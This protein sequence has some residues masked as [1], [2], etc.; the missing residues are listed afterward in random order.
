MRTARAFLCVVVLLPTAGCPFR[1]PGDSERTKPTTYR[2]KIVVTLDAQGLP[3]AIPLVLA[4]DLSTTTC[5]SAWA[6]GTASAADFRPDPNQPPWTVGSVATFSGSSS[7]C[8]WVS[9]RQWSIRAEIIEATFSPDY[10]FVKLRAES[11]DSWYHGSPRTGFGGGLH[12]TEIVSYEFRRAADGL[13][14]HIES[15]FAGTTTS[16]SRDLNDIWGN[17]PSPSATHGSDG[18]RTA[19]DELLVPDATE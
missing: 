13:H 15:N 5:D 4:G 16:F 6:G 8:P 7:P 2:G 11:R 18:E 17:G 9:M 10:S 1:G 19:L 12:V 14:A 3:D